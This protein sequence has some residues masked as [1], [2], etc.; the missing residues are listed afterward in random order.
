MVSFGYSI[1]TENRRFLTRALQTYARTAGTARPYLLAGPVLLLLALSPKGAAPGR[2]VGETHDRLVRDLTGLFQGHVET[3]AVSLLDPHTG[4]RVRIEAE[5]PF[6]AAST[7][8][9]G[10]LLALF[11]RSER[12]QVRLGR[13][14]AVRNS[15]R[16]VVD[17]SRYRVP[18]EDS[19][20]CACLTYGARRSR[21][22]VRVVARDMI[23][24]SSNLATNILIERLG[25]RTIE[26]ELRLLGLSGMRIVRG[27]YDMKAYDRDIH[28]TLTADA[29]MR[30]FYILGR[31][32]ALGWKAR[33]E[34]LQMLRRTEHRDKLPAELPVGVSVSQKSGYTEDVSHDAGLVYPEADRPYAVALLTKGHKDRYIVEERMGR[35]SRMIFD[36]VVQL[37]EK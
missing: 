15:F 35:A 6:P 17:G 21:L 16:S 30:S 8:K 37:R 29:A 12:G 13:S 23:Q 14:L 20:D 10:I 28:N 34:M 36:A 22:A 24:S 25:A 33:A 5:R 9:I 18:A 19:E 3:F 32:G 4:L 1:A 2:S 27:L 26:R 31:P 11:R 7:M